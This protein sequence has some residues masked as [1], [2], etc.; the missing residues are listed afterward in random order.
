MTTDT[1]RPTLATGAYTLPDAARLLNLP[2]ARLRTWVSGS[3]GLELESASR[4]YPAG[5]LASKGA[6]RDRTFCFLTLIELFSIAQLR[7]NGVGMD[8][9][10]KARAELARRFETAHPFALE[11]LLTDGRRLLKELGDTSLLELGTGGQTSFTLVLAPFCKRLDFDASTRLATRFFPNGRSSIV[12]VDPRHSFGRPIINGTNITTEA[13]ASL[14]RGGEKTED[15]AA[16]F[17]LDPEQVQ[18]AWGFESRLAA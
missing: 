2:L 12:V 14:I 7:D 8:T 9:L 1:A 5:Q 15:I 4:R 17:R 13:I 6:G 10:R 11:G 3:V 18:Q 16:D